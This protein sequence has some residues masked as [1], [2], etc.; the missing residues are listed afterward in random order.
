MSLLLGQRWHPINSFSDFFVCWIDAE[1]LMDNAD[2]PRVDEIVGE[3]RTEDRE[4]DTNKMRAV[5]AISV[6]TRIARTR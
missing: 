2:T 6:L 4:L 1:L 5:V 3:R